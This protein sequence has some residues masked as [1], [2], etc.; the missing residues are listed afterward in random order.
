MTTGDKE[1]PG[2]YGLWDQLMA[3]RW[4]KDNIKYFGGD[5]ENITVFG[6]SAGAAAIDLLSL[7]SYAESECTFLLIWQIGFL[8]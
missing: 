2:N 7:S 1:C 8:T 5:P 6:Q 4:I 3:L